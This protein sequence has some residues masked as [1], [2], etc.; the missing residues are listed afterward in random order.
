VLD[1]LDERLQPINPVCREAAAAAAGAEDQQRVSRSI[2]AA[3]GDLQLDVDP[4]HVSTTPSS[5]EQQA[6][7]KHMHSGGYSTG[8]SRVLCS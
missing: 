5:S 6:V 8:K 4:A 7:Y 3:W 2:D 1:L